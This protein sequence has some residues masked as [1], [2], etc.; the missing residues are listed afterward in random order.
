[1]IKEL[2]ANAVTFISCRR[3]N[4]VFT[5]AARGEKGSKG[6]GGQVRLSD[7]YTGRLSGLKYK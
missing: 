4:K 2:S 6:R 3:P 1:M 7:V 5:G